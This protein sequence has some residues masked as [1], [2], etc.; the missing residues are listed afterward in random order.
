MRIAVLSDSHDNVWK[1]DAAL[2]HLRR[3]DVV[4]HCGDLCSPFTLRL[5]ADGLGEKPI[6]VVWGNN[7]GDRLLMSRVAQEHPNIEL[8]G[9]LA[10]ITLGGMPVGV[11]HYP[12]LARGLASTGKYRLVCYGH[13][14]TAHYELVADCLLLNPGELMGLNGPSTMAI[15][16]TDGGVVTMIDLGP[17]N[18]G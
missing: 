1:M 12:E 17:G 3:A 14:H 18:G 7:D 9:D 4:I 8:H 15:V 16:E 2:D 6:H 13:D 11:N 10:Q 5:L